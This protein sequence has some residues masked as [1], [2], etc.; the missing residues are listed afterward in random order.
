MAI[1]AEKYEVEIQ[2]DPATGNVVWEEWRHP[3]D[4]GPL[5]IGGIELPRLGRARTHRIGAAAARRWDPT[6]GVVVSEGWY[7]RGKLHR[8]DG[9]ALIRR[10][11]VT[12][13]VLSSEWHLEG[14]RIPRPSRPKPGGA[15]QLRSFTPGAL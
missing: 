4:R 15:E 14:K 3:E 5:I 10:D 7:I 12:G 6:T 11:A 13:R 2:R 1:E 9:P 8:Q